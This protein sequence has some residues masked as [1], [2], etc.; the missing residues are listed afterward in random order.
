MKKI[1]AD[2]KKHLLTAISYM[3]PLVVA[4][5]LLIAIGNLM[6]G[7]VVTDLSQMT[8][9]SAFTSL[10]VLGMGLLPSFI[11]GYIAYSIADRPGIAPGFL[12]G[13]I[14]SFLGAGFLGG[15]IGGFVAGYIAKAIRDHLKVPKWAEALMPMMI[16]PTLTA[17]IGGLLMYFVL[18]GPITAMTNGLNNFITGL[19]QS[20]KSLYGFIIGFIGC[21]DYGGAISKVPNLICDGLLLEGIIE[22]EAIKVLAAMVPPLG[23]TLAWVISKVVKKRIFTNQEVENI[24]VAFPMGLCMISEG[25][26]PIAMNDLL[27][28]V[29]ATSIGCGVCGAISFTL[30][31]GSNVPS[32]GVFV[33]PAM[34]KPLAAVIALAVGSI[35]TALILVLIKKPL[36]EEQAEGIQEEV[37]EEVDLSGISFE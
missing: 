10:G 35:V 37:E 4:S 9:P 11:A 26:I 36:T 27:R 18:G 20:Q 3:L 30:G 12:M 19:D 15:M 2:I 32:G 25:V 23:V 13:Q 17:I 1:F 8:V 33:I 16:I 22:P 28:T 29:C 34:T 5:G 14:A 7:E 31:V 6:G 21:I 24:K